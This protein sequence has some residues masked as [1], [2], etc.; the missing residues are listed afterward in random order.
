[1]WP[2]VMPLGAHCR[3]STH[4]GN[5]TRLGSPAES[6]SPCPLGHTGD[7]FLRSHQC[8]SVALAIPGA[9]GG[10]HIISEGEGK[11]KHLLCMR[12]SV[13][14]TGWITVKGDGGRGGGGSPQLLL[15]SPPA[16]VLP[17]FPLTRLWGSIPLQPQFVVD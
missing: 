7:E 13:R 2:Q 15:P 14:L 6:R 1:M 10:G 4:L 16:A 9:P 5:K 3:A 11:G 17:S 8:S 12:Q